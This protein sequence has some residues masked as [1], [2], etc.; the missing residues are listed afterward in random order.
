LKCRVEHQAFFLRILLHY[1]QST[2]VLELTSGLRI[3]FLQAW[4][5][6]PLREKLRGR[7][8]VRFWQVGSSHINQPYR[9]R[10][11]KEKKSILVKIPGAACLY[12][13]Q[14]MHHSQRGWKQ[15][16]PNN[17]KSS[18]ELILITPVP[19]IQKSR[20]KGRRSLFKVIQQTMQKKTEVFLLR[21]PYLHTSVIPSLIYRHL[22]CSDQK[23]LTCNRIILYNHTVQTKYLHLNFKVKQHFFAYTFERKKF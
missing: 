19:K 12:S 2:F 1:C 14:T 7:R 11:C 21:M 16:K 20:V 9:K 8:R 23:M 3:A 17:F 4:H 13:I 6:G 18:L 15:K 10:K 5:I 22:C